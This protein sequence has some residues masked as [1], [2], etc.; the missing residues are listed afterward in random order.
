MPTG[1]YLILSGMESLK[2]MDSTPSMSMAD[3]YGQENLERYRKLQAEILLGSES[4]L[5]AANPKMSNPPKEYITAAPDFWAPKP[6]VAAKPAAP[7]PA[8]GQ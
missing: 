6:K 8:G 5:F 1:T 2:A 3:A 4:T 7:K